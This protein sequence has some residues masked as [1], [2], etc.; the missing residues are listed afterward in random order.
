[1]RDWTKALRPASFRGVP[2]NVETEGLAGGGRHVAVHEYVRS[3]EVWAEDMG[4]R[5]KRYRVTA[6]IANDLAD[7]HGAALVAALTQPDSGMLMLPM[8]GPV[9][10]MISGD[11]STNHSKNRLGYVGFD[12][13]AVEAG[14]ASLFPS[15]PLGNRIAATA[16]GSIA[17]L[18]R[19]FLGGFRP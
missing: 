14:G 10:V 12:F 4:R 7:V 11:I 8:L 9:E 17:G 19:T 18:A 1:M 3:E 16:A 15:V 13:E 6:Y 2:F 5:A